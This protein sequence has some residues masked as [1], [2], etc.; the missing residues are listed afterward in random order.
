MKADEAQ[1][2]EG[3]RF[4][5]WQ[6]CRAAASG[7][8]ERLLVSPCPSAWRGAALQRGSSVGRQQAAAGNG[9][10]CYYVPARISERLPYQ[11]KILIDP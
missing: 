8:R 7:S 1:R 11:D 5:T 6:L 2:L 4:V 10:W 9:C 3:S